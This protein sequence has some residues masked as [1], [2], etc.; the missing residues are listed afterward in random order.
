MSDIITKPVSDQAYKEMYEVE[1]KHWWFRS[2]RRVFKF[3]LKALKPETVLDAGCGTGYNVVFVTSLGFNAEGFDYSEEAIKYCVQHRALTN[4]RVASITQ[5]PYEDNRFDLI[6]SMDVLTTLTE[7]ERQQ[8]L[9]EL[10]RCTKVGGHIILNLAALEWLYS[11]HDIQW[12]VKKRYN[13]SQLQTELESVGFKVKKISYRYFF[14]FPF[15][16]LS[17]LLRKKEVNME[18]DSQ[19]DLANNS[20]IANFLLD[21]LMFFEDLLIRYVSFPVGS[22]IFVVAE[23]A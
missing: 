3:Y 10:H 8:A 5:M 23:K 2:L 7:A 6:Y 20:F 21:K 13:E 16:A 4:V 11:A 17:K 14:V 1:E 15:L 12:R 9:L 19:G 22:S 18:T